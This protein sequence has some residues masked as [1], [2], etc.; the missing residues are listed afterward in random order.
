MQPIIIILLLCNYFIPCFSQ[1][2]KY[3]VHG[4]YVNPVKKEILNIAETMSDINPGYPASW[5]SDYIS[6]GIS[7]TCNGKVMN[8]I[9]QNDKLSTDQKNILASADLGTDIDFDIMYNYKNSV[10]DISELH[11]MHFS[12]TV[13]P[14]VEAEYPGGKQQMS[15]YIDEKIIH[16]I[17]QNNSKK[18][19]PAILR[20]TINAK[21]EIVNA[22]IIK[23]S[24]DPKTDKIILKAIQKM[25]KWKP[26]QEANG[27][28]VKQ[29]F[30]ISVGNND[31]C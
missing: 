7:A 19:N 11:G 8:A 28:K 16:K 22:K 20:F 30:E 9:G 14:E 21:G 12:Y 26:A 25:L 23:S 1:S 4:L 24:D 31:G 5:V 27:S 2:I 10:T 18:I 6:S 17:S 13:V 29:E 3:E 15:K